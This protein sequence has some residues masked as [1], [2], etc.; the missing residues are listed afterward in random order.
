MH[1]V[2]FRM[3][4]VDGTGY[5]TESALLDVL[6]KGA[7]SNFSH[8]QLQAVRTVSML[9]LVLNSVASFRSSCRHCTID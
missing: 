5:V 1:A 8:Q 4:D 6:E 3:Y 7:G 9:P 2:A